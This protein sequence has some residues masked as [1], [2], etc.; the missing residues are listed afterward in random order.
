[1][2]GLFKQIGPLL[3]MGLQ[4]LPTRKGSSGVV[5]L[6]IAGVVASYI[7]IGRRDI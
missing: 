2:S 4:T 5:V 6:G 1:M 3:R 7:A